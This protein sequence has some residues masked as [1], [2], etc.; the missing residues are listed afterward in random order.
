MGKNRS[1]KKGLLDHLD[2]L[3]QEHHLLKHPFYRAWTEGS[4]SKESLQLYAEQYYQ[5]VRAY[6]EN[7]REL[8]GRTNGNLAQ[9]VQENLDEELDPVAP[10]PL[11]WR[12]F[13]ESLGVSEATLADARPLPGIAALLDTF[14]EIAAQGSPVQAVAAFY[15]YESQ[16]P[17][18]STQ[19]IA[20]LRRFYDITEP[21]ALGYFSAHE[22]ADVRHRAAWREW[23]A[24]QHDEGMFG[25]LCSA[26][27]ALKGLWGALDAVYPQ[28]AAARN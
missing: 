11:L 5:H 16:V 17:E 18:I 26:E 8:V 2:S 9:I 4:L 14:D 24:E 3:V 20:G 6:P 23:L 15:A 25:A 22:E 28:N 10:H 13:A 7:L 1:V 19:K 21:R 12:Q 27:R